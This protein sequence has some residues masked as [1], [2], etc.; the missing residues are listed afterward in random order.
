MD[1]GERGV[2]INSI[3]CIYE[4]YPPTTAKNVKGAKYGDGF[5]IRCREEHISIAHHR[6]L[7]ARQE[8]EAWPLTWLVRI[9]E[10]K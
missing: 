1:G 3:S 8:I 5:V 10:S 9:K 7:F 2:I 6:L 4:R